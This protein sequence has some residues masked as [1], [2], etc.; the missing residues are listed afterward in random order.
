MVKV[1]YRALAFWEAIS[2]LGAGVLG[3]LVY[4]DKL[5][6]EYGYSAPVLLSAILAVLGFLKVP[7]ELRAKGL[8]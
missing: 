8:L 3:L 2:W 6:V 1:F 5:P 4:F 7:V